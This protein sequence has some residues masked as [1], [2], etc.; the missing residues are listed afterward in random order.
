MKWSDLPRNPSATTLRQF[1]FIWLLFFLGMA[2][3]QYWGRGR[4]ELA[5]AI[6]AGA[7]L[8]GLLGILKPAA[9]RWLFVGWMIAAFPIGWMVSQLMLAILFYGI[10]TPIA[11]CFR[12][13]GRD[14]LRRKFPLQTDSYWTPKTQPTDVRRYFKQF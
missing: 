3:W 14:V 1:S 12:L 5:L 6:A 4:T 8:I 7:V 2:G 13:V 10:F 11:L 9:I